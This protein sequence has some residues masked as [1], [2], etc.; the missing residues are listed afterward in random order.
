VHL[1]SIKLHNI[2]GG[3]FTTSLSYPLCTVDKGEK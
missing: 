1:F 2:Y 3:I